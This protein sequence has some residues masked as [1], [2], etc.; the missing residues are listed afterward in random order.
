M[1]LPVVLLTETAN[2]SATGAM[3]PTERPSLLSAP[4][5]YVLSFLPELTKATQPLLVRLLGTVMR[6]ERVPDGDELYGSC[7]SQQRPLLLEPGGDGWISG[8]CSKPP[9]L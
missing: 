2:V 3:F 1:H 7:G 4:V 8:R 5:E 6:C 9:D